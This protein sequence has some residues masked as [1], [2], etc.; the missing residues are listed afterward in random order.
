MIF[1]KICWI[2]FRCCNFLRWNVNKLAYLKMFIACKNAVLFMK[3]INVKQEWS[4]QIYSFL[5][6]IVWQNEMFNLQSIAGGMM[7]PTCV[8]AHKTIQDSAELG[9][10][11]IRVLLKKFDS[12]SWS[13][14][15]Y[16]QRLMKV[17]IIDNK[18]LNQTNHEPLFG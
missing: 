3:S 1:L 17:G 9:L 16:G 6:L 7:W 15:L 18:T 4:K 5:G 13:Y 2:C 12:A 11:Y 8:C 10:H 14:V